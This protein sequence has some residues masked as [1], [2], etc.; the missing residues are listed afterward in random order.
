M[1]LRRS[2]ALTAGAL[3]LLTSCGFDL[4]TDRPYTPGEGT[5]DHSGDVAVLSALVVAAQ[6]NEGTVVVTLVNETDD[7]QSLTGVSSPELEVTDVDAI[8]VPARSH[9]N[10]A[11]DGG[12]LVTG[13]FDAGDFVPVTFTFESGQTT[14]LDVPVVTACGPYEGLDL[15]TGSENIPYDCEAEP[16]P[17]GG[18]GH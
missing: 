1:H 2:L 17:A 12:V 5:N 9:V 4:A 16:E 10:L 3:V 18:E 14:S 15:T 6:P 11:Q 7:E 13:D 8:T